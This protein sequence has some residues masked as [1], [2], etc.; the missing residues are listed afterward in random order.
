MDVDR[1]DSLPPPLQYPPRIP[2]E[3][4]YNEDDDDDEA[5]E[6]SDD[7]KENEAESHGPPPPEPAIGS[8]RSGEDESDDDGL[9]PDERMSE[10]WE[11]EVLD[12]SACNSSSR[13][14]S[15]SILT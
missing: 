13:F 6:R 8:W 1:V 3:D 5:A 11:L 10:D 14:F 2:D 9:T 4:I 15:D 7:E 12:A